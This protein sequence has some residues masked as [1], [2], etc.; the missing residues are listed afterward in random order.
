MT[1]FWAWIGWL[2]IRNEKG[3]ARTLQSIQKLVSIG[4]ISMLQLK[5]F[6]RNGC[7]LYAIQVL[8]SIESKDLKVE[9]HQMLWEFIY[10]FPKEVI[11]LPPEKRSQLFNRSGTW[12]ST[13]IEGALQD[14][15]TRVD[16][17]KG[18]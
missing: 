13:S 5:K 12:G 10:V 2:P 4:K 18:S 17:A 6:S 14:E 7:P 15:H 9:D 11:G 1:Y 8:N 3:N 16:R